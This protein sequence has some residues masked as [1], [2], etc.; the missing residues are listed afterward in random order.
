MPNLLKLPTS[1]K[2]N[3]IHVVVETP[4]NARARLKFDPKRKTF[5]LAKSP[6]LGLTYPFDWEF[7]LS[8]V[9]E[10]GDP[11]DVK[12]I[13]EAATTPGLVMKCRVIGILEA[14]QR[15][16][17]GDKHYNCAASLVTLGI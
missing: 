11:L 15:E 5:V 12:V 13:H 1:S 14:M 8:T 10:D 6:L 3:L 2:H 9:A 16:E 7:I 4:R 17:R